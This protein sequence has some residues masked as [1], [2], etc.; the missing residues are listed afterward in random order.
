MA[1][2]PDVYLDISIGGQKIGR[3]VLQLYS[4]L[5]PKAVENFIA[6]IKAHKYNGV[7]FHRVIKNF[8][9]QAGDIKNARTSSEVSYPNPE[10][11]K[12]NE[13]SFPEASYFPAE[14]TSEQF[15]KPF[16]LSMANDGN[17]DHNGCQ[18]FIS[19]YPQP[20]LSGNYTI[21]GEVIH[22]KSVVRTMERVATTEADV[23]VKEEIIEITDSGLWNS[24]TD[25]V[26]IYNANY[27]TIG[28][29][30]YEE[31][32]GD[33]EGNF[34]PEKPAESLKASETIKESGTLLFKKGDKSAAAMKYKK[35]L[36]Y[37]AEFIPDQD[38]EPEVYRGFIELKKKIYLNLS[39]VELQ[40]KQYPEVIQYSN[41]LLEMDEA[42]LTNQE[43]AKAYYRS[44]LA[45]LEL[46]KIEN[47][48]SSL[49]QAHELLPQDEGIKKEL[50]KAESLVKVKKEKQKAKLAK[51]FQ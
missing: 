14:N 21:F 19:T 9:V 51:F 20:H 38:Q 36:R 42:N 16:K 12:F 32:P 49:K 41:W 6:L 24:K 10:A 46:K 35:C 40:L 27:D 33:D 47:A 2:R 13:S 30:I 39:L 29:D 43:K 17:P 11:G 28:G 31:Y 37:I 50:S 3:I 48:A 22:G 7:Y 8:V 15:D 5:A 4:D 34:D 23:P 26:P 1:S 44:G 45:L 18:F 25:P